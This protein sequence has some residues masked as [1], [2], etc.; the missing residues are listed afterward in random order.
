MGEKLKESNGGKYEDEFV[1]GVFQLF[2]VLPVTTMII[3]FAIAYNQMYTVFNTQGLVMQKVGFID[4]SMMNNADAISVLASGFV[5]GHYLYPALEKRGIDFPL[6]Y[7]FAVGTFC[8]LLSLLTA[9]IIDY[10]IH[11]KFDATGEKVNI[12]WQIFPYAF[13]GAG[14]IFT[15]STV[16]DAAFAIAPKEQKGLASAINLFFIGG[17]PNFICMGLYEGCA[18][19]FAEASGI[20]AYAESQV[21]N[22]LWVLIGISIFGIIINALPPV[23]NYYENIMNKSKDTSATQSLILTKS[24]ILNPQEVLDAVKTAEILP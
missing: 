24:S 20:E 9:L 19:W 2:M 12:L 4:A 17:L 6:T 16:Y 7:K 1:D 11:S 10:R 23:K 21:Y 3:P 5:I 22:Y 14:E 18:S 8:G 15:F 13:I